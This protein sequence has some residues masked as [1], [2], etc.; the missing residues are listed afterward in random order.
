MSK[1]GGKGGTIKAP[2]T[3]QEDIEAME[4]ADDTA[5]DDN[6]ANDV[7][8]DDASDDGDGK[9]E[10]KKLR[11]K[12]EPIMEIGEDGTQR[13]AVMMVPIPLH[14]LVWDFKPLGVERVVVLD[15]S[16]LAPEIIAHACHHGIGQWGTDTMAL[17]KGATARQKADALFKN[18]AR[19]IAEKTWKAKRDPEAQKKA[20]EKAAT[21]GKAAGLTL[22]AET[23][24]K[25]GV[26]K[27]LKAAYKMLNINID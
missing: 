20:L 8:D 1:H 5:T 19:I 25:N 9:G 2:Q 22:A 3:S 21:D 27:D 15:E 6:G 14:R 12:R 13:H 17:G 16:K 26:A 10:K 18:V 4:D 24:V 11:V 7:S 23:L